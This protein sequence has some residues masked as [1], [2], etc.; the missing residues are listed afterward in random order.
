[1]NL[2]VII[3]TLNE[4]ENIERLV[5]R[6]KNCGCSDS[7]EII[8][9]DAGSTDSTQELARKAGAT[10]VLSP[11]KGRAPQMNFGAKQAKGDVLYFVHADSLPPEGFC[12]NIKKS[13]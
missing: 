13:A 6:L 4:A 5:H 2:S 11:K 9:V 10:A 1:M 3:P 12:L 7:H 8:V